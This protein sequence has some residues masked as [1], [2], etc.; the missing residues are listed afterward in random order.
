MKRIT[1]AA[2]IAAA[3]LAAPAAAQ[4]DSIVF[5]KDGNVWLSEPDGSG[6]YQVTSDGSAANPYFSPSQSDDGTIVVGRKQPNGGPLI[7][8]RQNGE[9]IN[10]IPLQWMLAGPFEPHVSPDGKTVAYRHTFS[11]TVNGYIETSSDVRFTRADGST[12]DG[13]GPEVGRGAGGPSW[14]D[15]NRALVGLNDLVYTATPGQAAVKWFSDLDHLDVFGNAKGMEDGEYAGGR[16]VVPR[17]GEDPGPNHLQLYTASGDFTTAPTPGCGFVNPADGSNGQ[18]FAD[19][20]LS[21]DGNTLVWQEGNG[22]WTTS[23]AS[24]GDCQAIA[25][26]ARLIVPGGSDPD[27]SPAPVNPPERRKDCGGCGSGGGSTAPKLALR[28][29]KKVSVRKALRRGV[30]L[31]LTA[32]GAGSL[33][34]TASAGRRRVG[35]GRAKARRAGAVTVRLR[36]PRK[37]ARALR[38]AK[39]LSVKVAFRPAGGGK[40]Q[41][42]KATVRLAGTAPRAAAAAAG[43]KTARFVAYVEGKQTIK[44]NVPKHGVG[45]NCQGQKWQ[46]QG[47]EETM[48]FATKPARLL[49]YKR[50][51]YGPFTRIG[52]WSMFGRERFNG[53]DGRGSIDRTGHIRYTLDPRECHDSDDPTAW[54]TGP[55]DCGK[56]EFRPDVRLAWRGNRVEVHAAT[57][58]LPLPGAGDSAG[59]ENCPVSRGP[60]GD[61]QTLSRRYPVKDVFDRSQGLVVVQASDTETEQLEHGGSV[62]THTKFKLRLR[63]AGR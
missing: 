15:S 31:R 29:P 47:G 11:S 46:E 39:R 4:A 37:S 55:Y 14:I 8:M 5:V 17:G 21:S 50:N 6:Q 53:L 57:L 16:L 56:R 52:T 34:A 10:T 59:Y 28:A 49:V 19:P 23:L 61:F 26:G 35:S 51:G 63:R 40:A 7:R 20:T 18:K 45:S 60:F 3:C 24:F 58:L 12:P 32:P 25:S 2:A 22:I 62:T 44:W 38:K 36:F 30:A 13:M 41:T 48:R 43:L 9:A 42:A 54:D 33:S 27:W 1:A